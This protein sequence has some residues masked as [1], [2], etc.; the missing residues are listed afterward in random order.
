MLIQAKHDSNQDKKRIMSNFVKFSNSAQLSVILQH[1]KE[2]TTK[3]RIE[4]H[5]KTNIK[6]PH[7]STHVYHVFT[8][9]ERQ[10]AGFC[11]LRVR[12]NIVERMALRQRP[13]EGGVHLQRVLLRLSLRHVRRRHRLRRVHR[14]PRRRVVR[15]LE[16][17][18]GVK[19]EPTSSDS[20]ALV[21]NE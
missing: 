18:K 19:A 9:R 14:S 7:N 13:G 8:M 2:R 11:H 3:I 1:E 12:H 21:T 6:R 4:R 15:S 10:I 20:S 16:N 5:L 17:I